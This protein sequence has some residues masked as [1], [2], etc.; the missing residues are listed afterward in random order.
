MVA[1]S[2]TQYVQRNSFNILNRSITFIVTLSVVSRSLGVSG[3]SP[4]G[5]S[6]THDAPNERTESGWCTEGTSCVYV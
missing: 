4:S 3:T 6:D 5:V 2:I 1:I